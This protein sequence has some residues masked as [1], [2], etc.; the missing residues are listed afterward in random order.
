MMC[1][2]DEINSYLHE[3]KEHT[4]EQNNCKE[5]KS[6]LAIR[7]RN[8]NLKTYIKHL[9][10]FLVRLLLLLVS[11]LSPSPPHDGFRLVLFATQVMSVRQAR[12]PHHF[13]VDTSW[14]I[15]Y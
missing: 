3:F 13:P 8:E 6:I 9:A 15:N 10:I 12:S 1:G 11:L 7:L 14:Q 4:T 2:S 5:F